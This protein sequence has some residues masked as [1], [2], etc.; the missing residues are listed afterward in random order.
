M[1]RLIFRQRR[2]PIHDK[3]ASQWAGREYIEPQVASE[4]IEDE[5]VNDSDD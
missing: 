2:I 3:P 1:E 4:E 5:E